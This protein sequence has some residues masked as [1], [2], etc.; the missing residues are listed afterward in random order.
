MQMQSTLFY[1]EFEVL[2]KFCIKYKEILAFSDLTTVAVM[3]ETTKKFAKW[4]YLLLN[5]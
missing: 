3:L 5:F 2:F 1:Q 4:Y